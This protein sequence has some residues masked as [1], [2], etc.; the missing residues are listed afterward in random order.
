MQLVIHAHF[1]TIQFSNMLHLLH[2][3]F[4]EVTPKGAVCRNWPPVT[5]KTNRGQ[6]VASAT[7]NCCYI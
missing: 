3:V 2:L 6:H 5:F 4:E 1:V 7:A